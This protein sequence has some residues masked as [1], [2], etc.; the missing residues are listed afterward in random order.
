MGGTRM[1]NG[2]R[3]PQ[4][5]QPKAMSPTPMAAPKGPSIGTNNLNTAGPNM[6]FSKGG[7]VKDRMAKVG[8]GNTRGVSTEKKTNNWTAK[9]PHFNKGGKVKK[10][11]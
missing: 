3:K 2:V 7:M 11:K 5:K 9:V 4:G 1:P 6:G 8:K 10:K